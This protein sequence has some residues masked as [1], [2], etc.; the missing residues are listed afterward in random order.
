MLPVCQNAGKIKQQLK[1]LGAVASLMSGSGPSVFGV[2]KT[3]AEAKSAEKS[4]RELGINAH[5]AYSI[6]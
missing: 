2:F 3:E 5:Y 1:D 6:T 4:L